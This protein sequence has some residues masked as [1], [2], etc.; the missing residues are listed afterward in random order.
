MKGQTGLKS[1]QEHF[2]EILPVCDPIVGA[3]DGLIKT[4][5]STFAISG[6][7]KGTNDQ[8]QRS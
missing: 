5:N 2:K 1:L 4:R 8:Q 6:P 3:R 7:L